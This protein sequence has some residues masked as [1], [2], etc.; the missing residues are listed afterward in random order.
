MAEHQH[1]GLQNEDSAVRI[2]FLSLL[3]TSVLVIAEAQAQKNAKIDS[4]L[5]RLPKAKPAAMDAV[6]E[7]FARS[8]L[9][10]TD[11]SGSMVEAD[12][13]SKSNIIGM[14]YTR[15]VRAVVFG[16]DSVTTVLIRGEEAREDEKGFTK[17]LRIDNKAGGNGEKIWKKMV[18]VALAL[19]STQVPGVAFKDK[20]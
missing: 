14:K 1:F 2:A 15:V 19:D 8:G 16:N 6:L 4:L 11:N 7:A 12:L 17:R 5:I 10:V 9:D 13:G 18:A 20:K 3:F